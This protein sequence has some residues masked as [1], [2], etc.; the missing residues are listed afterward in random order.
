MVTVPATPIA[1][2][3]AARTSS[4][5]CSESSARTADGARLELIR[6]RRIGAEEPLGHAHAADVEA[7]VEVDAVR[8]ADDELGRAAADV[9]DEGAGLEPRARSV[10]PRRVSSAS[11]APESSR[12]AN[13]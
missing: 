5:T 2:R 1:V 12:V 4:A 7:R 6:L 10:T 13:P 3:T 8:S 9:H 11:S